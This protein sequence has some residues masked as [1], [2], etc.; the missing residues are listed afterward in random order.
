MQWWKWLIFIVFIVIVLGLSLFL[1][2]GLR[3]SSRCSR[4]EEDNER[5]NYKE[6]KK[7]YEEYTGNTINVNR[8]ALHIYAGD[9]NDVM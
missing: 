7:Y 4:M 1:Y 2:C 3:I 9:N 8:L 5:K 6:N